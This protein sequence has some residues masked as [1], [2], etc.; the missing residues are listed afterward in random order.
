M[1]V[2]DV[3]NFPEEGSSFKEKSSSASG[4]CLRAAGNHAIAPSE[5]MR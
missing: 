5:K 4:A 1:T 2:Y 3:A